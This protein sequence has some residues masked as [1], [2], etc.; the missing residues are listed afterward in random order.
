VPLSFD[1]RIFVTSSAGEEGRSGQRT[2]LRHNSLASAARMFVPDE[3][4]M[5]IA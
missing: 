4:L 3:F 1:E 5:L 2:G